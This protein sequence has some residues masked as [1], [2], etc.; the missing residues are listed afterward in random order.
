M[1]IPVKELEETDLREMRRPLPERI[2]GFLGKRRDQAFTDLEI[3]GGIEGHSETSLTIAMIFWDRDELATVLTPI[4]SALQELAGRGALVSGARS[5]IMYWA[6]R[7]AAR[8]VRNGRNTR[9]T[10]DAR[11]KKRA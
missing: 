3:L 11:K 4:R 5:G 8:N 9:D 2:L 7:R 6:A 1:P 10:R